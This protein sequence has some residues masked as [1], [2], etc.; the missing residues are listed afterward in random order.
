[1]KI[2]VCELNNNA[3]IFAEEWKGLVA[4]VQSQ[5]SDIVLLPELP[6]YRWFGVTRSESEAEWNAA[7]LAHD[8]W[9]DRVKDLAPATVLA[10]RPIMR[11]SMRLNEGFL[12]EENRGYHPVHHKYYLPDEEGF[13]EASWYE[14]GKGDFEPVETG[15]ISVG[16]MICS[17][18]WFFEHARVY[19]KAGAHLIVTPRCT[20]KAS[21]DSWIVGGRAA[22][23]SSGSFSASSNRNGF[24]GNL[25]FGGGGWIIDPDG[26]VLGVTSKDMPFLTLDIDL[27]QA[28]D[29]KRTYPRY[30]PE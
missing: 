23:I 29:A 27:A 17:E 7:V 5:Q 30:I 21:V 2:T 12:W 10:T 13:W 20:E 24:E 9:L 25:E 26:N 19:G 28:Q 3:D 6:F 14:R 15:K 22:A 16:F 8:T 1:M 18:L 4:H 11:R